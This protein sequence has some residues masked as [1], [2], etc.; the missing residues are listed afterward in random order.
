MC[1]FRNHSDATRRR[2]PGQGIQLPSPAVLALMGAPQRS[3]VLQGLP[4]LSPASPKNRRQISEC[5]SR[6]LQAEGV[7][8]YGKKDS[9]GGM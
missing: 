1:V 8:S 4:C 9:G 3:P 2:R 5:S 6:L 7:G